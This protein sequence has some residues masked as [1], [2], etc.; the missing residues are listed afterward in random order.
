MDILADL[1]CDENIFQ[2]LCQSVLFVLCGFDEAQLNK[3]L[4]ETI[5]HHTPAGT[6]TKTVVHYA[7]EINSKKF[8][9]YDFGKHN[10]DHYGQDEPPEFS[11]K[12]VTLPI[13][14]Y[15]SQ[16]DWLAQPDVISTDTKVRL[17]L[18]STANFI[19]FRTC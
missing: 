4:L 15:W 3:T 18:I 9:H 17:G 11:L 1:V 5:T 2:G 13:A 16:N 14:S 8:A 12:A 19:I 6:S 7:Q 10:M